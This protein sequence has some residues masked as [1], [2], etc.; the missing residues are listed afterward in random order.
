MELDIPLVQFIEVQQAADAKDRVTVRGNGEELR[1]RKPTGQDQRDW[2]QHAYA[3]EQSAIRA[4]VR[5]LLI[6]EK[7][8]PAPFPGHLP[9]DLLADISRAL[10]EADPLINYRCPVVCPYCDHQATYPIDLEAFALKQLQ[11]AQHNLLNNV[12]RLA[13]AYHWSEAE[14]FAV[15]PWRRA[16]Y[17]KRIEMERP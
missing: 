2:L 15:P 1:L 17:L 16:L 14:I 5:M 3:D 7:E 13:S 12:H 6:S 4:M 10:D 11:Q 8:G 9:A